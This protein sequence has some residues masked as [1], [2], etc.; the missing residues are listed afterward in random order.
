MLEPTWRVVT[1]G[2]TW[3]NPVLNFSE[4]VWLSYWWFS[5]FATS[6]FHRRI[7]PLFWISGICLHFETTAAV[8]WVEGLKPTLLLHF[9]PISA[10]SD[11]TASEFSKLSH[12]Q[13]LIVHQAAKFQ[14]QFWS[15]VS[16]MH[17]YTIQRFSKI[18]QSATELQRLNRFH[19]DCHP[20]F[21]VYKMWIMTICGSQGS[22]SLTI[23]QM[24]CIY[25]EP[26]PRFG[27]KVKFKMAAADS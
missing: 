19:S 27:P 15:R 7:G 20:P 11:L 1:I 2:V 3:S 12:I 9:Y 25:L 6:V 17:L 8:T 16:T 10:I 21:W 26:W 23:Y 18:G 22:T 14:F 24:W 4:I 5:K 13:G